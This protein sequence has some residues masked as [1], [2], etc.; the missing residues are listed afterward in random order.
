MHT[1]IKVEGFELLAHA[2][3]PWENGLETGL[4]LPVDTQAVIFYPPDAVPFN[5]ALF[6]RNEDRW[7]WDT[8]NPHLVG[9]KALVFLP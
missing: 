6:I 5:T 2:E 4:L 8:H 9:D 3:I 1:K 7:M